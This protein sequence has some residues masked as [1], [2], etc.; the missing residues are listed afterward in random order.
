MKIS[1]KIIDYA[2]WY[3]LRYYPS[4]KKMEQKLRMKFWPESEK[5]KKY[6][7]IN[8][9]EINYILTEKLRNIIQEDE[10]IKS[11][12][13]VYKD[14]WKSKQYI[15]QKLYQRLEKSD[16]IE[17]YLL[18]AFENWEID[19]VKKEYEKQ[20]KKLQIKFEGYELKNKLIERLIRKWFCYSDIIQVIDI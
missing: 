12:I 10:V 9:E 16:L 14:K 5:W 18:E 11:K 13:R 17:K 4:P 1:Q 3:Y 7:W 8:K 19:L 20:L 2:I 15:K 6:W